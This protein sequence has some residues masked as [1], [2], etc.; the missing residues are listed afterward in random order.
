MG[1]GPDAP[2]VVRRP[3]MNAYLA[4]ANIAKLSAGNEHSL[5]VT[6]N[7]ELFIWGDGG[8]CGLGESQLGQKVTVPQ[9]IEFKNKIQ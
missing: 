1:L 4:S 8:L 2:S 7:G 3:I 6:K 9:K 5:G